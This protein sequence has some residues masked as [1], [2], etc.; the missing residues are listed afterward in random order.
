MIQKNHDHQKCAGVVGK[1]SE[2]LNR[3]KDDT[4]YRGDL[5]CWWA[6]HGK[7]QEDVATPDSWSEEDDDKAE[8]FRL[9]FQV[10]GWFSGCMVVLWYIWVCRW[11]RCSQCWLLCIFCVQI[12]RPIVCIPINLRISICL[13]L[14]LKVILHLCQVCVKRSSS[15]TEVLG[16]LES[17]I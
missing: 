15:E 2:T 12:L 14:V 11:D 10:W 1:R 4:I 16:T 13:V 5:H 17:F 9:F 8:L 3:S 7:K 6:G